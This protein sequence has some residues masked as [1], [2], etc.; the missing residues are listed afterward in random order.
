MSDIADMK[1]DVDAHLWPEWTESFL[2]ASTW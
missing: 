1:A 2:W